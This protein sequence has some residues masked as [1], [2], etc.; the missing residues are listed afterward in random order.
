MSLIY[1]YLIMICLGF[2]SP[3]Q[4]NFWSQNYPQILIWILFLI[5]ELKEEFQ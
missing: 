4:S 1:R 2:A 5:F 3:T